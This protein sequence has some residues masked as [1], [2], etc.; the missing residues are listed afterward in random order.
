MLP[1]PISVLTPKIRVRDLLL[2][3]AAPLGFE[4][5]AGAAGLEKEITVPR[6][7][8]PGLALAGFIEYIHPG[9]VQI[10]GQSEITFLMGLAPDRRRD[11][12]HEVCA[13]GVTCFVIT[14]SLSPPEE[15]VATAE[16]Y[17]IP[18]LR[19][20]QVSSATIDGLT[21]FLEDRLAPRISLHGV[22]LDIYGVGVLLLG[23]SGVGKSECALDLIVRGHRLV[24]D[25]IVE[26]KR[27]GS[28]LNGSGPELTRYH[29][30]IRGLGIINIKDLFGVASVRYLKDLDMVV[31]LDPWQEGKEYERLG[32]DQR[33]YE[34]LGVSVPFIEMPVAP[35]RHLSVLVEVAARNH[36]LKTKGY[37]PARELA[38]R[39][40]AR[41]AEGPAE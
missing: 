26:I 7:Q 6:I 28:V 11:I 9:R 24:S 1:T 19:T 3:E 21:R 10:L 14:K 5:I 35:G 13:C 20:G 41:L 16:V 27:K 17:S 31:K 30:E 23:D 39:L 34:I 22:L 18:V 38:S 15:L 37:D 40:E 36:L 33:S 2:G 8:K 32:L 25:D 4:T 12:L 29:M